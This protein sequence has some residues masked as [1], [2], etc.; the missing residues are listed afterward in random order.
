MSATKDHLRRDA[1]HR[2]RLELAALLQQYGRRILDKAYANISG[3]IAEAEPGAE[4]DG[5][6]IGTQAFES[7]TASFLASGAGTPQEAIEASTD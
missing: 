1:E 6:A 3:A 7:A 2:A 4:L 5:K